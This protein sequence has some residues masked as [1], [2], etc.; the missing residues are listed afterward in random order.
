MRPLP[1]L[2]IARW[3][4]YGA[5]GLAALSAWLGL[6]AG[7]TLDYVVLRGVFVF[8]VFAAIAFAGEALVSSRGSQPGAEQRR[9][10][11]PR[12]GGDGE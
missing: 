5:A 10:D 7:G 12:A 4:V 3:G 11:V 9:Q 6:Q 8:V 1:P 2:T